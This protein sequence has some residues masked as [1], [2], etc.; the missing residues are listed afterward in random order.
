MSARDV[1]ET[2]IDP[3]VPDGGRASIDAF[4]AEVLAEDRAHHLIVSRFDVAYE[5][6]PEEEPV[7]TIGAIAEDGRPVA[8]LLDEET[9]RKV[10]GWVGPAEAGEKSSPAGADATPDFFQPGHTYAHSAW[11]FRCD[12]VTT[13]PE[14]G[15]R[16]ALGWFRFRDGTWHL[17][18]ANEPQWDDGWRDITAPAPATGDTPEEGA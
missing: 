16:T 5:P 13:D 7:L 4:A 17:Y 6:A 9:R 1:L 10:A 12:T 2:N 8:L 15:E 18:A 3:A 14:H 11:T